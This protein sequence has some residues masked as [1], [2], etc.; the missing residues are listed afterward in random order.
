[1]RPRMTYG[2][3]GDVSMCLAE[4]LGIGCQETRRAGAGCRPMKKRTFSIDPFDIA[5][6]FTEGYTGFSEC[7]RRPLSARS[8]SLQ[9]GGAA[10][11]AAERNH[12]DGPGVFDRPAP[13]QPRASAAEVMTP[14]FPR[15]GPLMIA[16]DA[17]HCAGDDE[18]APNHRA[19]DDR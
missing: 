4:P 2:N 3:V 17:P 15:N 5:I 7:R 11:P 10:P 14:H 8:F 9:F 1:M 13:R 19:P 16:Y 6:I 18:H 12:G